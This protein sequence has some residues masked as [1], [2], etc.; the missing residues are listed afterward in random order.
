MIKGRMLMAI[1]LHVLFSLKVLLICLCYYKF[2]TLNRQLINGSGRGAPSVTHQEPLAASGR[3]SMRS[4]TSAL[5]TLLKCTN[6]KR[7][8]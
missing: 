4:L 3:L 8:V 2:R 1:D 5:E 6:L 7:W